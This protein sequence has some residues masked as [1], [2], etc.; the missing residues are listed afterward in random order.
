MT[1]AIN[2]TNAFEAERVPTSWRVWLL[3][4][5]PQTLPAAATPVL[6]GTALALGVNQVHLGGALACLF[7]AVLIQVGTNLVNDYA[8]FAKGA[9]TRSRVG[10]ARAAER[11]WLSSRALKAGA[12]VAFALATLVGSYLVWLAGWPIALIGV[13][14]ILSGIA[15]TSGPWPL[16][17]KGLGDLFV[18]LFFGVIA[19]G[20]TYYVQTAQLTPEVFLLGVAVGCFATA[21]LGVSTCVIVTPTP[22]PVNAPS[23][24]ASES[25]SLDSNTHGYWSHPTPS[26]SF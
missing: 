5:R 16:G 7:G 25:A 21:I 20:G 6:V 14:S 15:Y 18:L 4:M 19:V 13:L 11:G 17:Y 23:P 1:V 3:A 12:A 2:T 9:D 22:S 8:D 26:F 24:Y 10:P